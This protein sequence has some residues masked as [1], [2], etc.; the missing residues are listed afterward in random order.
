MGHSAACGH[1]G[2][3]CTY[4]SIV[5]RHCDCLYVQPN[6]HWHIFHSQTPLPCYRSN[7]SLLASTKW[8]AFKRG[9]VCK[10]KNPSG[11]VMG[12]I[13]LI[14]QRYA[15]WLFFLPVLLTIIT[16]GHAPTPA[17]LHASTP[18]HYAAQLTISTYT[19]TPPLPH[20]RAQHQGS[21][22]APQ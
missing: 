15:T 19:C 5:I 18:S 17:P 2:L 21:N 6:K 7:T 13:R 22:N 16:T 20:G 4:C 10:I 14:P 1:L 9:E 8:A 3:W 12:C 11:A